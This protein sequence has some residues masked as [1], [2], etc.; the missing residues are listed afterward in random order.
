MHCCKSLSGHKE[1]SIVALMAVEG[2]H[3]LISEEQSFFFTCLASF[4]HRAANVMKDG[5]L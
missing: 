5:A 2:W 4:L 3:L 1:D